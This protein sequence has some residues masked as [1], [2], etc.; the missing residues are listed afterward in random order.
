[1]TPSIPLP[2]PASQP[3]GDSSVASGGSRAHARRAFADQL[4]QQRTAFPKRPLAQVF[5]VECNQVEGDELS[6]RLAAESLDARGRRMDAREESIEIEPG[7][8]GH[9]NLT[10]ESD[11]L[12]AQVG[13][14]GDE[15]GEVAAERP[16]M[17][18]AKV[19]AAR[20]AEGEAAKAVP[21]RL[22]DPVAVR[23]LGDPA[24]EH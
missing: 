2:T 1:M 19:D 9:D 21:L 8:A 17:A 20:G 16:I 14:A 7:R 18:A 11:V 4:R 6:W 3:G 23:Q 15:F 10:I 24:T 5:A 13:H 12:A 22:V